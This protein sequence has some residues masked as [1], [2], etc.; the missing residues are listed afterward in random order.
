M[1]G[2]GEGRGRFSLAEAGRN[3]QHREALV[4]GYFY[5]GHRDTN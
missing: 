2:A 3:C 1:L 4:H 5:V